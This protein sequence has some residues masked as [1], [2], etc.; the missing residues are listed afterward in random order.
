MTPATFQTLLIAAVLLY[1][2]KGMILDPGG[3]AATL[4]R[5]TQGIHNFQ[6]RLGINHSPEPPPVPLSV[7]GENFLRLTGLILAA[8]ALLAVAFVIQR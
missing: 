4:S 7:T 3:F 2:A 6:Q 1:L 5:F 8:L